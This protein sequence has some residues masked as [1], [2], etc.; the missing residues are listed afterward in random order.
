[1]NYIVLKDLAFGVLFGVAG[2]KITLSSY[3]LYKDYYHTM[4]LRNF[5]MRTQD[6]INRYMPG[7]INKN[8]YVYYEIGIPPTLKYPGIG[9]TNYS[10]TTKHPSCNYL[11]DKYLEEV[12]NIKRPL[13]GVK[14]INCILDIFMYGTL[15]SIFYSRI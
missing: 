7:R 10:T 11:I 15:L 5:H 14:T 12:E 4:Y 3:Q 9:C 1:M 6:T 2:A 13:G 8:G